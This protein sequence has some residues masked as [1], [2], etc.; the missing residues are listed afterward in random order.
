[1]DKEQ[2]TKRARKILW[3]IRLEAHMNESTGHET[4]RR[5]AEAVGSWDGDAERTPFAFNSMNLLRG[6]IPNS[7][8]SSQAF[9]NSEE[10]EDRFEYP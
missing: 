7:R 9:L 4:S 6:F 2:I 5:T 1:L 10:Y 3:G 8:L